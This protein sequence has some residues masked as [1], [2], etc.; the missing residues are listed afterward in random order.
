MFLDLLHLAAALVVGLFGLAA[1]LYLG[2]F[3]ADVIVPL[4]V[5]RHPQWHQPP[6]LSVLNPFLNNLLLLSAFGIHHSLM[7]R[8]SVKA[9]LHY[10][11]PQRIY[12]QVYVIMVCSILALLVYCWQ[13]IPSIVWEV[14]NP[15]LHVIIQSLAVVDFL[16][17][18]LALL[19]LNPLQLLGIGDSLNRVLKRE[20]GQ[21]QLVTTGLY[22]LARH[23]VY[24]C[25]IASLWI[26]PK[27]TV[28]RLLMSSVFTFYIVYATIYYE[29]PD[30]VK[31]LG[32]SYKKYMQDT[33]RFIPWPKSKETKN[34]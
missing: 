24:T 12:R 31:C 8:D 9:V 16:L 23:P 18:N 28:G 7:P 15:I 19:W 3:I 27:M 33:P 11:I 1:N 4:S 30:L 34:E 26:T 32:P 6:G 25:L 22:G 5:D 14:K 21:A 13:P 17:L 29:E 10:I 2:G 20:P